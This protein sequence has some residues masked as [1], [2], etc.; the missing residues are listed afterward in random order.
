MD[1]PVHAHG[2]L[3]VRL[4]AVHADVALAC[5]GIFGVAHGQRQIGST[6]QGPALQ[7]GKHVDRRVI[8][9]DDLLA[10]RVGHGVWADARQLRQ[11]RDQFDLVEQ[12]FGGPVLHAVQPLF[13]TQAEVVQC[14]H[15][16]RPGHALG[17]AEEIDDDRDVI[18]LHVLE[19]QRG[20]SGFAHAVGNL[21]NFQV[22]FDWSLDAHELVALLQQGDELAEVAKCH[23]AVIQTSGGL[24]RRWNAD[25]LWSARG[26]ASRRPL[27]YSHGLRTTKRER[28]GRS[29]DN[30]R[31]PPGR[32]VQSHRSYSCA[33]ATPVPQLLL[34][35]SYSCAAVRLMAAS[36]CRC[37]R[38]NSSS[39]PN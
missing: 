17:A 18:A 32:P 7:D 34:C 25:R 33:A 10:G 6:I 16:Q 8:C 31:A 3:I 26:G 24:P 29:C 30:G 36:G 5:L 1:L 37:S 11:L 2:A 28:G 19:E 23:G 27:S 20:A 39:T 12:A 35:R 38:L 14:V 22:G 13:D 21:S 15:A 9:D 4:N